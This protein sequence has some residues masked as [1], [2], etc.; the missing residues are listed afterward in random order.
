MLLPTTSALR[1][2]E[3]LRDTTGIGLAELNEEGVISKLFVFISIGNESM[4]D[5]DARDA[6]FT[7]RRD[8]TIIISHASVGILAVVLRILHLDA[9][10]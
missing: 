1:K 3:C 4:L 5:D 8:H 7:R 9:A 10:L 6:M 2:T